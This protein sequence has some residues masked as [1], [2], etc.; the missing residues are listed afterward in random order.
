[1]LI[2]VRGAGWALWVYLKYLYF[3][4]YG[5]R[6]VCVAGEVE[7]GIRYS[8]IWGG[9][10]LKTFIVFWSRL[11]ARTSNCRSDSFKSAIV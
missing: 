6:F 9:I 10:A 2:L 7:E 11:M 8:V 5:Y 1:M 4:F 3:G